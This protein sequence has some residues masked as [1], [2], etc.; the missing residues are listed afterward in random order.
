MKKPFIV[1]AVILALDQ[2]M[3]FLVEKFIPLGSAVKVVGLFDFF[4]ITH[5]TNT[6]VAF[7]FFQGKN[8]L[9]ALIIAVFLICVLAWVIKN[10][11]KITTLQKY[12]FCLI[13]AGG[14]GN[15]IDRIFRGAV[16]D[17]LDFG[18]NS[19]RWPSF[20]VADSCVCVAAALVFVDMCKSFKKGNK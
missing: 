1:C 6:G 20:N 18:I 5:V 12:A 19:L 7:S 11:E 8:F 2:L 9:F 4:N 3:K 15:L 10:K 14:A 17:F 13:I 16:V